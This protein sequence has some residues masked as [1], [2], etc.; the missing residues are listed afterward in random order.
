MYT[1]LIGHKKILTLD[2]IEYEI[3]H[4]I[5]ETYR[6]KKG[7]DIIGEIENPGEIFNLHT[8]TEK[9]KHIIHRNLNELQRNKL[10]DGYALDFY[11]KGG[12][13]ITE[14]GKIIRECKYEKKEDFPQ[15]IIEKTG[16]AIKE[17]IKKE[18]DCITFIPPTQSGDKVKKLTEELAT[19]LE[20]PLVE[21]MINVTERPQKYK[22]VIQPN[23]KVQILAQGY[24]DTIKDKS[25]LL[26]DDV[27]DTG[28]S[29]RAAGEVL[30][31]WHARIIVPVV[32]ARTYKTDPRPE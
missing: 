2:G 31:D 32:L 17:T 15:N 1:I 11:D 23:K 10:V 22:R 26:I 24:M 29:L 28:D 18:F 27:C 25:I 14:V 8:L 16:T 19:I 5:Q 30:T 9:T 4:T 13:E 12:G 20:I 7:N 21:V 6:I 3:G